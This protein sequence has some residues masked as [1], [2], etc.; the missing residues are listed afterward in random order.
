MSAGIKWHLISTALKE[1]RA[2]F[3]AD[4]DTLLLQNPFEESTVAAY[5][6]AAAVSCS[7]RL[8]FQWEGPG[9]NPLNGGQLLTCSRAAVQDVIAAQPASNDEAFE[10]RLDQE[11]AYEALWKNGHTI[12]PLPEQRFGGNCWWPKGWSP[13]DEQAP[14]WCELVT[15]HAHCTGSLREKLE[16]LQLVMHETKFCKRT[17]P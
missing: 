16:R 2:I 1:A 15:F 5:I 6:G 9:S 17:T 8:R 10:K 3:F 12:S 4:A 14:P 13:Q 7:T 11:V